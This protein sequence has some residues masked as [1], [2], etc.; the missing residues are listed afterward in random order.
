[1]CKLKNVERSYKENR[2]K[3]RVLRKKDARPWAWKAGMH[4]NMP[5]KEVS[6]LPLSLPPFLPSFL[7]WNQNALTGSQSAKNIIPPKQ[8]V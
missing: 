8:V 6:F 2:D 4:Y 1:M 7:S 3:N 5:P